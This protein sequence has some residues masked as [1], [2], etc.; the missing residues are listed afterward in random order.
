MYYHNLSFLAALLT[1]SPCP[2][3]ATFVT[4]SC[5]H[6]RLSLVLKSEPVFVRY[7]YPR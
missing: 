2:V 7:I 1:D 5:I 3:A 4:T 6:R